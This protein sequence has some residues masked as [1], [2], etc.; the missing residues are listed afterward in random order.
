MVPA[1]IVVL[2]Q[3]PL[4][5]SG[6]V[7]RSAL[8][9][10]ALGAAT[11]R[12]PRTVEAPRNEIE[13][14]LCDE[15]AVVL[16]VEVGITDSF[17]TLVVIPSWRPSFYAR[18]QPTAECRACL[19]RMSLISQLSWISQPRFSG[20]RLHINQSLRRYTPEPIELSFAQGRL[21]FLESAQPRVG[22]VYHA[23]CDAD[24]RAAPY[25]RLL[26]TAFLAPG[27]AS[28]GP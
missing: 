8:G 1:R 13:V 11:D 14:V 10:L 22:M 24:A 23:A 19:L 15:F 28:S 7:D 18:L 5:A 3:M 21:W 9:R 20:V 6:K 16:G 4:N 12:G 25:R 2:D 27:A 26:T 17:S